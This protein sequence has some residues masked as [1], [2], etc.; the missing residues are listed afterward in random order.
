MKLLRRIFS[1]LSV[2]TTLAGVGVPASRAQESVCAQVV[3]E[4]DQELT[5]E[6][7]GFEAR[8]GVTN[9]LP[10]SLDNFQVTLHFTDANGSPVRVSTD[11][12]PE[13]SG[14]FYYR[15]QT[16]CTFPTSVAAGASAKVAY[17]IVPAP[18]AAGTTSGGA[19]YYIGATV[20]YNVSGASRPWISL[21]TSSLF[22][23]CR[24]SS[25]SISCRATCMATTR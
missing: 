6:R 10:L 16:G 8:L 24:S 11:A 7:E 21:P 1:C 22:G 25:F 19:L 23:P 3:I 20:K 12:A 15:V 4:I 5:L 14:L 18:G 17:L 13:S 9:G 2:L